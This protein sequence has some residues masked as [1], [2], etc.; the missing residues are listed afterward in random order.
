MAG[1]TNFL[2]HNPTA[3]NQENDAQY[4]ADSLRTGGI[5]TDAILPSEWLNKIWYQSSTFVAAFTQM[6]SNKGYT[7]LDADV[8]ALA[9][10]L[11][12]VITNADLKPAQITVASSPNPT[13][14]CS[15]SNGFRFGLNAN[16]TSSTCINSQIGQIIT[17][18]IVS[19]SPGVFTF[20]WPSNVQ[21]PPNVQTQSI[22]QLL[23][24]QF[25]SDGNDLW[26]LSTFLEFLQ[27]EINAINAAVTALQSGKQNTLGFTPVQQ[28]T[29]IGQLSNV[30][31][32]GWDGTRLRTTVDTTDE[33]GIV[34]DSELAPV[35]AAVTTLQGTVSG[36]QSQVAALNTFKALF[37][38]NPSPN[39]VIEIP[40]N[41]G[42]ILLQWGNTGVFADGNITVNFPN[43][44]P[45]ACL[46]V[47]ACDVFNGGSSRIVSMVSQN[48]NNFT[49]H[50]DGDGN[51]VNWFAIG[52]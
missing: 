15:Q 34:F 19:A 36:I 21:N 23:S 4:N 42:T 37:Q 45:N 24:Y 46:Q 22:N 18:F 6:M 14:D 5:G 32:I 51:S 27:N 20:A 28:G 52:H 40:T 13:F 8:N 43:P 38:A 12:N 11:A 25:I 48:Q 16:V 17:F 41:L 31:K 9:A 29:G 50:H 49:V 10:Q 26:P 7:M 39:G 3:A 1:S 44:F 35:S 47:I 30:I 2:Q 33:G